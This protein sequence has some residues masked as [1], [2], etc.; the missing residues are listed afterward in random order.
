MTPSLRISQQREAI[1]SACCRVLLHHAFPGRGLL[2]MQTG[3]AETGDGNCKLAS[4]PAVT[5]LR[6]PTQAAGP[7]SAH[8]PTAR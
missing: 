5:L 3:V 7:L 6:L 4:V 8:Q 1:D 2:L